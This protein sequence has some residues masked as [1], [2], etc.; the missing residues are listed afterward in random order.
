MECHQGSRQMDLSKGGD[1]DPVVECSAFLFR[2]SSGPFYGKNVDIPHKKPSKGLLLI[3]RRGVQKLPLRLPGV[4]S[5]GWVS[6]YGS[7]T[8]SAFGKELPV[9]GINETGMVIEPAS[10]METQYPTGAS[11]LHLEKFQWT[12]HMLDCCATVRE[13][14]EKSESVLP[15][16]LRSHFLV[17]DS[18]GECAAIEFLGGEMVC[19]SGESLPVPA[20]T[21]SLYKDSL[22]YLEKHAG[23]GGDLPIPPEYQSLPNFVRIA[24]GLSA[25]GEG[26]GVP[27][28]EIC[29]SVLH[30]VSDGIFTKRSTIYDIARL[31][32]IFHTSVCQKVRFVDL[33]RIDFSSDGP[34]MMLD[35]DVDAEGDVS[36]QFVPLTTKANDAVAEDL[37]RML[38]GFVPADHGVQSLPITFGDLMG[39][40]RRYSSQATA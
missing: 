13:V 12:Q 32:A 10:P 2:H 1:G 21:N 35:V 16:G 5:E 9:G 19:H 20:I 27:P 40:I 36:D 26:L 6:I 29:F 37:S 14:V 3:N 7:L 33:D 34:A 25:A 23:F 24:H 11:M 22:A 38:L 39:E 15:I 8:F 30:S 31:W 28:E 4:C 18:T 17:T